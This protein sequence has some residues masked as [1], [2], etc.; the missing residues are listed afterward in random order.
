LRGVASV[1]AG[2]IVL[3]LVLSAG[4]FVLFLVEREWWWLYHRSVVRLGGVSCV[5]DGVVTRV[6]F[7]LVV[8]NG[9]GVGWVDVVFN[10][11][12]VPVVFDAVPRSVYDGVI[13]VYF[14]LSGDWSGRVI[15]VVVHPS[16]DYAGAGD[17][18][19]RFLCRGAG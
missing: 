9:F 3:S 16:G 13:T 11:S 5:S 12:V 18:A 7:D 19:F 15:G 17:F 4:L 2:V 14:N 10:G 1:V 8:D 6:V